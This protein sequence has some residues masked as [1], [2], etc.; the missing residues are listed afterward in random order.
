MQE[1]LEGLD[2]RD[3][4][5]Q[6]VAVDRIVGRTEL[7]RLDGLPQPHALVRHEHVVVVVAGGRTVDLSRSLAIASN[8][9]AAPAAAGPDTIDAGKRFSAS[10]VRPCDCGASDGSPIGS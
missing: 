10:V 8:A 7:P 4:V 5:E 3:A 6:L 9:F 2:L 1:A